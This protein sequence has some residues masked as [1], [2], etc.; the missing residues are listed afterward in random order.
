MKQ[1]YIHKIKSDNIQQ[2][3]VIILAAGSN[4][5]RGEKTC[6]SLNK[7]TKNKKAIDAQICNINNVFKNPDIIVVSGFDKNNLSEHIF[8]N[9]NNVRLIENTNYNDTTSIESLRLAINA[10]IKSDLCIINGNVKFNLSALGFEK[11]QDPYLVVNPNKNRQHKKLGILYQNEQVIRMAYGFDSQW[12]E[13]LYIPEKLFNTIRDKIQSYEFHHTF[14]EF[15]ND[16]IDKHNIIFKPYINNKTRI[17][18][19]SKN[20]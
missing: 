18:Q 2:T 15:I 20:A 3:T 12:G 10:S 17:T 1:E 5:I 4:G 16:L 11:Q 6:R 14:F 8:N 7:V 9:Y 13:I 19:V